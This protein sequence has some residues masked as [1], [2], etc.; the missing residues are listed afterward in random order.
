MV[1]SFWQT[2]KKN[3]LCY[4]L[5]SVKYPGQ[6]LPNKVGKYRSA[7]AATYIGMKKRGYSWNSYISLSYIAHIPM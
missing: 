5:L 4:F 3:R 1:E 2:K 7:P 6:I